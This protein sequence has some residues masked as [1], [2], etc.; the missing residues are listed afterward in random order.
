MRRKITQS[1]KALFCKRSELYRRWQIRPTFAGR[2]VCS[3]VSVIEGHSFL[4]LR[5][6]WFQLSLRSTRVVRW[7]G[8]VCRGAS[9]DDDFDQAAMA[10]TDGVVSKRQWN[11]EWPHSEVRF[12]K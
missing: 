10:Q 3:A 5:P 7:D 8:R 2:H 9:R 6:A 1:L 12:A 11:Y 4:D